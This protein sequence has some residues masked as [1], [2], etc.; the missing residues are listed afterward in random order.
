MKGIS[1]ILTFPA[2]VVVEDDIIAVNAEFA[3]DRTQ[4]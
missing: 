1:K 2:T 4:R 3:F